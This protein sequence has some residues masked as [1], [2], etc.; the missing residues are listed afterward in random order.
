MSHTPIVALVGRPNAGKST[1]F[2]RLVGQRMAI[3]HDEPGVTRDRH[4]A[5]VLSHGKRY[6][7]VDTAG[8]DPE[9]DDPMRRGMQRQLEIAL[10]E[11]DLV[12]CVLD[13]T[14]PPSGADSE[15]VSLLR[16]SDKPVVFV[17]NKA[18]SDRREH[19][20]SELY[21]LGVGDIVFVSALHG[22]G[23]GELEAAIAAC[24]PETPLEPEPAPEGELAV[25]VLG[26]PNAGKSSLVNR[27]LG[28]ERLLVS[29]TPG[30]TRDP[31]D[32]RVVR[33]DQPFL[34]VDTAGLRKKASVVRSGDAVEA[35]STFA[36]IRAIERARV[37]VLVCDAERGVGE[38]DAK[39][40]G[41]V[42]D[43]A[44]ALVVALNKVDLL[45]RDDRKKAA[46]STR[47]ALA[48]AS[49]APICETS[50]RT[51]RGVDALLDTVKRA[52]TSYGLRVGTGELNRF[53]EDVL[54]RH[55]P[56]TQG[57]KA[58]RFYYITQA[59]SAPPVFVIMTSAPDKIHWSYRRY[60][61]NA[62]RKA[63]GF[64]G[65]PLI[66]RYREPSGRGRRGAPH[67]KG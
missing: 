45:D 58:P 50:A 65:S 52:G 67:A 13:A 60:V 7:L 17:A 36:A 51:G 19:E 4:Y 9:S 61:A 48:F 35:L 57:G 22:R 44:R 56:P 40:A 16:R 32:T 6:T 24:L 39:V 54:T 34:F 30:T 47:E 38:Q 33:R 2:N 31:I 27:I 42:V 64:E 5:D 10:S 18:D 28:E 1:L 23:F 25:A 49:W 53:F 37:A 11:A 46:E 66:V 3:V 43:R 20:A 41:L 21:R 26:R 12:V 59:E 14:I 15:E 55:P 8:F 62:I 63:F 29:P